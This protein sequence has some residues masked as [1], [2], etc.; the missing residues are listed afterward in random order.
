M[1][2]RWIWLFYNANIILIK[3]VSVKKIGYAVLYTII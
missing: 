3:N 1:K 2:D